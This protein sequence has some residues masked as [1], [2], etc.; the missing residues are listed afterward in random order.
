[1]DGKEIKPANAEAETPKLWSPDINR[2][3]IGKHPDAGRDQRQNEK[4]VTEDKMVR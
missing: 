1:M 3:I 4:G 2:R